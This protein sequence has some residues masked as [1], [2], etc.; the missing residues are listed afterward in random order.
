LKA[1]ILRIK[2]RGRLMPFG[3]I[4]ARVRERRGQRCVLKV[5]ETGIEDVL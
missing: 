3:R 4:K 1:E 2:I 5:A